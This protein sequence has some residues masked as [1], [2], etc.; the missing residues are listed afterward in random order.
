MN[1][2]I[3]DNQCHLCQQIKFII[4]KNDLFKYFVWIPSDYSEIKL[5]FSSHLLDSTIVLIKSNDEILTEFKACRYILSKIP[6]FWPTLLFMYI[7]FFSQ[8]IGDRIYRYIS[9]RRNCYN[10]K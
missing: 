10:G 9:T 8:Y 2:V 4:E 3:Y 1:T 5:N 7:P 6:L